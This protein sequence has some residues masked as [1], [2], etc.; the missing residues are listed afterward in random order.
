MLFLADPS[1]DY[2]VIQD[3][4]NAILYFCLIDSDIGL[5]AHYT[6]FAVAY[7]SILITL[8]RLQWTQFQED[9]ISF[10]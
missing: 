5:N 9:F 7:A 3:K 2:S 6:S 1:F 4:L 10:M 8:E